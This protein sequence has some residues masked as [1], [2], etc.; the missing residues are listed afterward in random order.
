MFTDGQLSQIRDHGISLPGIEKQ[1]ENFR[2]GFAFANLIKPAIVN[3][4]ILRFNN[5]E[6]NGLANFYDR[7]Q[8][9]KKLIKFVPASGAASRMF[10]ELYGFLE[11]YTMSGDDIDKFEE[12][13]GFNSIYNFIDR[14]TEFA[15]YTEL[16]DLLQKDGISIEDSLQKNEYHVIIGYLLEN[17]GLGYG[18]LPKGLLKFHKYE[19]ESRTPAMEHLAEGALY[20]ESANKI[21]KIH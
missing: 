12:D 17:H 9:G 13:R 6:V 2:K 5:E 20:A 7:N 18:Q 10:K 11:T 19:H 15:F 21:V 8:N 3:D 14:L 4:G 1:I 16:V